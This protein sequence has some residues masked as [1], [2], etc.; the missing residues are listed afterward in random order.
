MLAP[1]QE[2]PWSLPSN[3]TGAVGW[4]LA[5]G[6]VDGD[7]FLGRENT[8][9]FKPSETPL[10]RGVGLSPC[11]APASSGKC[12]CG[13]VSSRGPCLC[14][15]GRRGNAEEP[16]ACGRGARLLQRPR[17]ERRPSPVALAAV[18]L[19]GPLLTFQRAFIALFLQ[20]GLRPAG[21]GPSLWVSTLVMLSAP[22]IFLG[23]VLIDTFPGAFPRSRPSTLKHL[24][25]IC[26]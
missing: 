26:K 18:P 12:R 24:W 13:R 2:G 3:V 16:Q 10:T 7:A 4:R 5:P 17:D 19:S 6:P 23:S 15:S 9:R 25:E 22:R 1:H 20:K 11:I 14:P 21:L 8:S